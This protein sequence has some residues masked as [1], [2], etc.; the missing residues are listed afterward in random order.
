MRDS[1]SPKERTAH[2]EKSHIQNKTHLNYRYRDHNRDTSSPRSHSASRLEQSFSPAIQSIVPA[3][4]PKPIK[5]D[6]RTNASRSP[7]F[8][9]HRP[10]RRKKKKDSIAPMRATV[11]MEFTLYRKVKAVK[12]MLV[13]CRHDRRHL[14]SVAFIHSRTWARGYRAR[15]RR[16]W[17]GMPRCSHLRTVRMEILSLPASS[18]GVR[19][20]SARAGVGVVSEVAELPLIGCC[21]IDVYTVRVFLVL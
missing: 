3:K 5:D 20:S 6:P 9:S 19:R 8:R 13:S 11:F 2:L 12:G 18:F 17:A 14:R 15:R 4:Q 1:V 21:F 10:G 16:R 7:W